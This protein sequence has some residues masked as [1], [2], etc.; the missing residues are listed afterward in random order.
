[1]SWNA[2]YYARPGFRALAGADLTDGLREILAAEA[3]P[4]LGRRPR[5]CMKRGAT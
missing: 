2:P 1:M 4:G 3:A 5:V